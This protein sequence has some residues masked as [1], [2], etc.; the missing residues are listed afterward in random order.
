MRAA[1]TVLA[2]VAMAGGEP[3]SGGA[4]APPEAAQPAGRVVTGQY[5]GPEGTRAY[6]LYVPASWSAGRRMPLVVMLHGCTQNADDI[7]RGTRL[8]AR[9][10]RDGFLA[11]YPE[12]PASANPKTCWNWFDPAHQRRGGEP[13][14]I[15]AM[16]RQVAKEHGADARRVHVAGISAGGAMALV[17]GAAYPELFASVASHSGVAVG[18]AS[19]PMAAV[20][21][22][23]GG[24][25]DAATLAP[26]MRALMGERRRAVPLLVLHGTA[27]Q[28]V[29]VVNAR[30]SA[31][32][33]AGA[34]DAAERRTSIA[35]VT[36]GGERAVARRCW[37]GAGG[38][39]VVELVE[40]DGLGH[41]W[42]GGDPA[43]TFTDARGPDA[44]ALVVDFLLRHP[45]STVERA[46]R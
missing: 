40:V 21:V 24:A 36:P 38:E 8:D 16:T 23:R 32:Q 45:M 14:L 26:T 13:A 10:E 41:A 17:V 30:Q 19:N 35:S 1:F 25:V 2:M 11:L 15:A 18:A 5:A 27:D 12:Q 46:P 9:A 7:A 28:V 22:M 29:N 37:T 44:T 20:G 4:G 42:S 39:C 33:W 6:R 3:T 34:L 43:G 31:E